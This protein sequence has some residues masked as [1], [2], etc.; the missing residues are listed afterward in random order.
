M[1]S[2]GILEQRLERI[3]KAVALEAPDRVP[4]VLEYAGFAASATQTPMSEFIRSRAAATRTMIKAYER[5]GD[6]DAINYGSFSPYD[7][8]YLFGAKVKVPGFDL[9][10]N[11]LWQVAEAELMTAR[12]YDRILEM[13]WPAFFKEF[14]SRQILDDADDG[15]LHP[16]NKPIDFSMDSY[17]DGYQSK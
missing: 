7:L 15:L 14:L 9:P 16:N 12:D 4:V 2:S 11:D 13:G 10:D 8:C 17:F 5:V 1:K 6:G 3:L